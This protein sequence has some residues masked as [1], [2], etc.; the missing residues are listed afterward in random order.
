MIFGAACF[1][2][3]CVWAGPS[4]GVG[5]RRTQIRTCSLRPPALCRR[6]IAC[7]IGMDA[8]E[9]AER[10]ARA[11][12]AKLAAARARAAAR[13]GTPNAGT[14]QRPVQPSL[15][16]GEAK[17]TPA[18]NPCAACLKPP[19]ESTISGAPVVKR[20]P[21]MTQVSSGTAPPPFN[22]LLSEVAPLE[23]VRAKHGSTVWTPPKAP[24]TATQQKEWRSR[25]ECYMKKRIAV[26]A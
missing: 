20:V 8:V 15:S 26:T 13:F 5:H 25:A 21:S 14:S 17:A 16:H 2:R 19:T 7:C 18:K 10:E 23:L 3:L 24:P 4:F 22:N 1:V 6:C 11:A 9:A 12:E